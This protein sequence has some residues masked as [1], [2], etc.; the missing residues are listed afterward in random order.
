MSA[1]SEAVEADSP[2]R[3]WR[4]GEAS[5]TLADSTGGGAITLTGGATYDNN[6]PLAVGDEGAVSFDGENDYGQVSV[7]LSAQSKFTVEFWIKWD[8]NGTN[9][10]MAMEFTATANTGKGPF[11]IDWNNSTSGESNTVSVKWLGQNELSKRYTFPRPAAAEWHHIVL[12]LTMNGALKAYVDGKEVTTTQRE[13]HEQ[14]GNFANSTLNVMSRNGA[15]LFGAGDMVHLAFYSGELSKERIEAHYT[16]QQ[17]STKT[18]QFGFAEAAERT[19]WVGN[20]GGAT[21]ITVD[22]REATDSPNDASTPAEVQRFKR[23]GKSLTNGQPYF[24]WTGT[25]EELGVPAGATVTS[26]NA[27]FD[28]QCLTYNTGEPG[29]VGPMELRDE[30]GT[31][32]KT[33]S[34]ALTFSSTTSFATRSGENQTGLEYPA[35]K[36]VKLRLNGNPK[37]GSKTSANVWLY[38][39]WIALTITYVEA[40][41]GE[42]KALTLEFADEVSLADAVTKGVK[43]TK[44]DTA[45]LSDAVSKVVGKTKGDTLTLADAAIRSVGKNVADTVA[46]TDELVSKTRGR[47]LE[48][49]DSVELSDAVAKGVVSIKADT[50]PLSDAVSKALTRTF[51]DTL[52][53]ADAVSKAATL[54]FADSVTLADAIQKATGKN[55]ADSVTLADSVQKVI[56]KAEADEVSLADAARMAVTMVVADSVA[57]EDAVETFLEEPPKGGE[58]Y[59]LEFADSVELS[60][61]VTKSIDKTLADGL[62]LEDAVMKAIAVHVA[63]SV[64][65]A[66]AVEKAVGLAL[67]DSVA[68][69][70]NVSKIV[71]LSVSDEVSLADAVETLLSGDAIKV[72]R[73]LKAVIVPLTLIANVQPGAARTAAVQTGGRNA[74]VASRTL[75]TAAIVARAAVAV[76]QRLTRNARID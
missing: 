9:D 57:L 49:A 51:A 66:D 71:G 21:G 33:F 68:L 55:T 20:E 24:E 31:L 14:T 38:T 17:G 70:D 25:L 75:R 36:K 72:T 28:W 30:A 23:E 40:G 39:D 60:D 34:P 61:A 18:K 44:A 45:A 64:T 5:G 12:V 10:D 47:F 32:L 3:Y 4:M 37:T 46:L 19:A 2:L 26:I 35:S 53:L 16:A 27:S 48:F 62:A 15:S 11:N 50:A 6:G 42:G 69:T 41:G 1:Y 74:A 73:P 8:V 65:V 63:D 59:V 7:D 13:S 22:Y 29:T 52:T 56:A 76:V 54:N 58:N 43:A 67:S